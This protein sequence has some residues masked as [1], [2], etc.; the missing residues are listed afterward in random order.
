MTALAFALEAF[1]V[2]PSLIS[3]GMDVMDFINKTSDDL[4]KMQ[5]TGSDPTPEQWQEL[6]D[7]IETLR[8]QRPDVT[9][10]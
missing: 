4:K 9:N 3:A 5:E 7:L 1:N 8:S 6:R 2:L 10:E